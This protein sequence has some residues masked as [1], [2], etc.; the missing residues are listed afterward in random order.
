MY[1]T[2]DLS[3]SN[4][5]QI[6]TAG[7]ITKSMFEPVLA[8]T[9]ASTNQESQIDIDELNSIGDFHQVVEYYQQQKND[10]IFHAMLLSKT[11][12]LAKL[13]L[14]ANPEL[15]VLTASPTTDQKG[16][17]SVSAKDKDDKTI[18]L[19]NRM[20]SDTDDII[21]PEVDA[22]DLLD[23]VENS[24]LLIKH[25]GN[26]DVQSKATLPGYDK[27]ARFNFRLYEIRRPDLAAIVKEQKAPSL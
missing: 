11:S 3:Y 4:D 8:E 6:I 10:V 14:I 21:L 27:D 5:K 9:K 2:V 22:L 26:W 1:K 7:R 13:F 19:R 12:D 17:F 23:K 18:S 16:Y 24:R 20:L 15:S 25:G